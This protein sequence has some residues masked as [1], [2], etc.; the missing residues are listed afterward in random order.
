MNTLA[1]AWNW[2]EAT[3]RNLGRM[4][5]L[6]RKHWGD[7]SL[8]GAS[9]WQ[10]D[11]F[12][13]LEASDIVAETTASLKPIDDLAVVVLFSVFESHVRDYLVARIKPEAAD[14]SDPILKEAANDAIQGVEEGSFFRRVLQPL[15]EQGHVSADLVTQIDQVRDYRNWVAHGRRERV[16]DMNNVTPRMAY[17]RL[18]EFLAVL[19]I[20]AETERIELEESAESPE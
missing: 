12:K 20:A 7:A 8:E 19:G 10:D 15:K 4:Q 11:H 2:Y 16:S 17:E 18:Q 9:L 13:R 5:R 6:G 3:K 14:L 1:D